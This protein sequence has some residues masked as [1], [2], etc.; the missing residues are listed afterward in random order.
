MATAVIMP[1]QGQSVESCIL[2]QWYKQV[3]DSVKTGD[4]LFSYETDKASFEEEAKQDGVLLA[5]FHEEND[6]V[7][8]LEIVCVIGQVGEDYSSM[9]PDGANAFASETADKASTA[10]EITSASASFTSPVTSSIV[11]VPQTT[12]EELKISPRAKLLAEQAGVDPLLATPTGPDNRVITRDIE[13]LRDAGV[14]MASGLSHASGQFAGSGIGGRVLASDHNSTAVD[15]T[16]IIQTPSSAKQIS[17][18]DF[19]DTPHTNIRKMIAKSML[20]SITTT[21]QLTLNASFN[22]TSIL[23]YRAK[24][25]ESSNKDIAGITLNDMVMY[26][27]AKTLPNHPA[28]NAHFFDD[29]LRTFQNVHLGMAVDTERG[30]MVPTLFT[31]NEMSLLQLSM[32]IKR[33]ARDCQ[34][35][36]VNP[37]IL[38]GASF[39]VTNLGALGI[40]SFTPVINPP[41]TGI[42]GVCTI[43]EKARSGKNGLEIYQSM[44]LSLTFDHRA[45]DG[46]PAA[47]FLKDLGTALEG[48]ETLLAT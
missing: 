22:A 29:K 20:Q 42:L 32:Q 37:D 30:L 21:C 10:Q 1:R 14:R 43:T 16:Q 41:Q 44:G 38:K 31:A 36:S 39:T 15:T 17:A 6:D 8:C 34:G 26:A 3:G 28:L 23:K 45:I 35:G 27:V 9:V 24:L 12:N 19:T 7:P 48:F 40:E 18:E 4:I 13:K 47:R 46:A 33:L 25:K 2:S 11:L 5:R